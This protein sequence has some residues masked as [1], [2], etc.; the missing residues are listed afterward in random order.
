MARNLVVC[1]DGT[2]NVFSPGGAPTNVARL[3]RAL[4]RD[5]TAQVYFYDPGVG[6]PDGYLSEGDGLSWKDLLSR[7]AGLAWGR[8]IWTNVAEAY[9]FLVAHYQPGDRIFLFGFSRG[10]F[11]ARAVGGLIHLCGLMK[12]GHENL[13]PSLLQ[14]YR[15]PAGPARDRAGAALRDAFAHPGVHVHFTGVWDTVESV[16]LVRLLAGATITS[17]RDVKDTY[18]HVR[19]AVALDEQRAPY[20]PRLYDAPAWPNDAQRSFKQVYFCGAHSDV[21]GSYREDG[22]ANASLHWM[23]REANVLGLRID[24]DAL[25]AHAVNALDR[26]H[27]EVNRTPWWVLAGVFTRPLPPGPLTVH[28]SVV[29]RAQAAPGGDRPR[30]PD[31]YRVETTRTAV[32]DAQGHTR[33][34][35]VPVRRH[36]AEPAHDPAW[37]W[38]RTV[39]LLAAAVATAWILARTGCEAW[40]L[41]KLQ[42]GLERGSFVAL[43]AALQARFGP[44]V[45]VLH[46]LLWKDT[47]LIASYVLLLPVALLGLLRLGAWRGAIR[48]WLGRWARAGAVLVVADAIENWSTMAAWQA[49]ASAACSPLPCACVEALYSVLCSAAAVAKVAACVALLLFLAAC[50]VHAL[51]PARARNA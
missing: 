8:G 45:G 21:G 35:P 6:T 24:A 33:E 28:E 29:E 16:G 42:L 50:A 32:I 36:A 9:G 15:A 17:N 4:P 31:A 30:L 46:A 20:L 18:R 38:R 3:V 12:R 7:M 39:W 14:V 34:L 37:D 40:P 43:G 26:R 22:L 13:V 49:S 10:A 23:V 5:D 11:T 47:A 25:Q 2:G 1:C 41:V 27:D 48:P 19:H 44:D 51:L